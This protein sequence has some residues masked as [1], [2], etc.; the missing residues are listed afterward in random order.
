MPKFPLPELLFA[1]RRLEQRVVS[2]FVT[3]GCPE[4][5]KLRIRASAGVVRLRGRL[6]NN[7]D[8]LYA[9]EGCQR[10]AGV[11]RVA[12]EIVVESAN[13]DHDASAAAS[14]QQFGTVEYVNDGPSASSILL[15]A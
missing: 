11:L 1:D 3:H 6:S 2:Y 7:S 8:R 9:I 5:C 10:V 14:R 4:L 12:D 15:S 13:L